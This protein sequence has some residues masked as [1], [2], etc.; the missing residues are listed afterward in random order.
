MD[1]GS[2]LPV[3]TFHKTAKPENRQVYATAHNA[4]TGKAISMSDFY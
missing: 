3:C 4:D 2:L 1:S